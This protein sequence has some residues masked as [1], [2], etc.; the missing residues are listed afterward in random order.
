MDENAMQHP[1]MTRLRF[2]G[3][4]VLIPLLAACGG[5]PAS[6]TAAPAQ[7]TPSGAQS[8]SALT[9]AA[10]PTMAPTTQQ[11]GSPTAAAAPA[12]G[13]KASAGSAAVLNLAWRS[14]APV[15]FNPL[16]ST[17]GSEQQV[18]R[19]IF[20]ALLKMSDKLEPTP[21]LAK[22]WDVSPD[23]LTFTFHLND[24]I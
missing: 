2:L 15:S 5:A 6:P 3:L 7:T 16:F 4:G 10:A 12:S 11:V 19:L 1:G 13:A 21:D 17:S 22:S 24:G 14:T 8:T 18:E 23:A 9:A 20:G